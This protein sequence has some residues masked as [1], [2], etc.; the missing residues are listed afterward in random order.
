MSVMAIMALLT[1]LGAGGLSWMKSNRQ[2]ELGMKGIDLQEKQ[3]KMQGASEIRA[4]Q[5]KKE[6]AGEDR[7]AAMDMRYMDQEHRSMSDDK[8]R[9]LN[10][11][12]M[13]MQLIQAL[14][15]SAERG[16]GGQMSMS[17]MMGR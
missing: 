5:D 2:H 3:L 1:A 9:A 12:L 14:M 6:M 8:D 17:R 15:S 13:Q 7:D 10:E 4:M 11:R 16:E